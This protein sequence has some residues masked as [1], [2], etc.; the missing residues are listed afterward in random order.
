MPTES[1]SFSSIRSHG[2]TS[3]SWMRAWMPE[4]SGGVTGKASQWAI[5]VKGARSA[6]FV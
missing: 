1:R 6:L 4:T 3:Q 5:R 2:G